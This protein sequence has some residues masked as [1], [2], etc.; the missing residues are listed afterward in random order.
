MEWI[1]FPQSFIN[2][3]H[4]IINPFSSYWLEFILSALSAFDEH[5][6]AGRFC[7]DTAVCFDSP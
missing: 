4:L 2:S 1:I 7:Y 5:M 3:Y 6:K